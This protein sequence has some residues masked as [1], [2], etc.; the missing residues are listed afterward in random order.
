MEEVR[1]L[2]ESLHD[3][4]EYLTDAR[5]ASARLANGALRLQAGT[6]ALSK[7]AT[8]ADV[9]RVALDAMAS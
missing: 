1:A 8:V 7:A 9:G 3:A 6:E 4:N 5:D 2:D